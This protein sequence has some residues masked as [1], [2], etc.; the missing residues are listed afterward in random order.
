M[1]TPRVIVGDTLNHQIASYKLDGT[2]KKVLA[3]GDMENV[4]GLA[5]DW[6]SGNVFWTNGG[7][8]SGTASSQILLSLFRFLF[9]FAFMCQN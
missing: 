9:S 1:I 4:D 8:T 2:G 7:E 6:I 5:V 3:E